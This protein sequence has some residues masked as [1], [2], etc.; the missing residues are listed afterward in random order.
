MSCSS[1]GGLGR[2]GAAVYAPTTL[3]RPNRLIALQ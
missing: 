1:T 2:L 3:T